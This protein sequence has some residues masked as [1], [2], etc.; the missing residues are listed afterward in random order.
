MECVQ[1]GHHPSSRSGQEGDREPSTPN[2]RKDQWIHYIEQDTNL[3][4][5]LQRKISTQFGVKQPCFCLT[6]INPFFLV[7]LA[8]Q[9]KQPSS[10]MQSLFWSP[11]QMLLKLP[12]SFSLGGQI[13]PGPAAPRWLVTAW[14]CG[15]CSELSTFSQSHWTMQTRAGPSVSALIS[16]EQCSNYLMI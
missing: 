11:R 9:W 7:L 16:A 3:C 6:L 1:S 8:P 10:S 14:L 15:C 12:W 13:I 5:V 4:R 2:F